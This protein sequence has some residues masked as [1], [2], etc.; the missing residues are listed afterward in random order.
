MNVKTSRTFETHL[1]IDASRPECI[2]HAR[3]WAI[4]AGLKWTEIELSRGN[5]QLQ[6]MITYWGSDSLQSQRQ[7]AKRIEEE[8]SPLGVHIV[9]FK[10][11][12]EAS[13]S[14]FARLGQYFE[15]HI[16][17][18]LKSPE[19]L[20]ALNVVANGNS[21]HLSRNARRVRDDGTQERFLTQRSYNCDGVQAKCKE[22]HLIDSLNK[23]GFDIL[24]TESEF[25]LFDS[26][27]SLDAGWEDSN[28]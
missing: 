7:A 23:N 8:L 21:S 2:E 22:Q 14:L 24:E 26:N 1:T 15:C 17:L 20:D 6:P 25:V 3:F 4:E 13:A 9:R 18:H 19:D 16:K 10:T 11:E 12:T 5:H 28:V 27:L